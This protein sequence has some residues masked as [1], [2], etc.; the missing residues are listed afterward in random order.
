[1]RAPNLTLQ[2]NLQQA[3]KLIVNEKVFEKQNGPYFNLLYLNQPEKMHV[4]GIND[5]EGFMSK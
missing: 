3:K 1:M 4:S 5:F 2:L